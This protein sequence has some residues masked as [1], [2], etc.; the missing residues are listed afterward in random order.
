MG[1]WYLC[2]NFFKQHLPSRNF[3]PLFPFISSTNQNTVR[4]RNWRFLDLTAVL[5]TSRFVIYQSSLLKTL[6]TNKLNPLYRFK[7]ID[8]MKSFGVR[9]NNASRTRIPRELMPE[10]IILGFSLKF[11]RKEYVPVLTLM[12]NQVPCSW[13]VKDFSFKD[14]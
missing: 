5:P 8:L 9:E 6:P 2:Q 3:R 10:F 7:S 1:L 12:P 13:F 4:T 11:V 14:P